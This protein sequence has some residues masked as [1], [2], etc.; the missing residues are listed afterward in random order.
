MCRRFCQTA[1]VQSGGVLPGPEG[2]RGSC[3]HQCS[4]CSRD[5]HCSSPRGSSK[6]GVSGSPC[7]MQLRVLCTGTPE[8]WPTSVSSAWRQGWV[9]A[10]GA[11][12][13]ALHSPPMSSGGPC[14]QG[15]QGRWPYKLE[16]LLP[17][18]AVSLGLTINVFIA[19]FTRF[20]Q[21]LFTTFL[22]AIMLTYYPKEKAWK[23]TAFGE[24]AQGVPS[25]CSHC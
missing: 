8:S 16:G 24:R 18:T 11:A 7:R 2:T 20:L 13:E 17:E 12:A 14:R 25:P 23:D 15:L 21:H 22:I 19:Y 5:V 4:D 6:A 3:H 9:L 10:P 1:R